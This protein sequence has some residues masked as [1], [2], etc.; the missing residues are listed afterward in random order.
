MWE[1]EWLLNVSRKVELHDVISWK[2]KRVMLENDY[3]A[4]LWPEVELYV[5][6]LDAH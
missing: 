6:L 2:E 3:L 1:I 4:Y 5:H